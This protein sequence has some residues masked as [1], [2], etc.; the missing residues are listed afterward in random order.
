MKYSDETGSAKPI[1]SAEFSCGDFLF[2]SGVGCHSNGAAGGDFDFCI[3]VLG[4]FPWSKL[5][6][7]Q[8]SLVTMTQ[9]SAIHLTTHNI[10]KFFFFCSA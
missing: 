5:I 10:Y 9:V 1:Y 4:V 2:F 3:G 8:S 6:G 7:K